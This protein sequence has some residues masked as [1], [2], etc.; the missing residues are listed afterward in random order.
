MGDIPIPP[1]LEVYVEAIGLDL[2]VKLVAALGG[3]REY[4]PKSP[5][6]GGPLAR[7]IGLEAARRLARVMGGERPDIP[8]GR[9]FLIAHLR[10]QGM[11][12]SS[13]ARQLKCNER[14]VYDHLRKAD[15]RQLDLFASP[16]A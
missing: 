14:T 10:S 7:L 16:A 6:A 1:S 12:V 11:T 3:S 2:T 9:G 15:D 13:I 8:L 4:I 5:P